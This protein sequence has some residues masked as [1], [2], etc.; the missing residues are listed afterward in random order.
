MSAFFV[1][2]DHINAMLTAAQM[3]EVAVTMPGAVGYVN[4]KRLDDSAMTII[5]RALIEENMKSLAARYPSDWQEMLPDGFDVEAYRFEED[6]CFLT[7]HKATDGITLARCYDYQSCEHDEYE[8]SWAH[9][10]LHGLVWTLAGKVPET[11]G[12]PSLWEYHKP[13][14]APQIM[15]IM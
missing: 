6:F 1:G 5:G 11:P 3:G 14:D 8:A 7:R 13:A 4:C 10:F 12:R 2:I 9:R 15:R